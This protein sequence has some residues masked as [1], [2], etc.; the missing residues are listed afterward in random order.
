MALAQL[1]DPRL[2]RAKEEKFAQ[3][4]SASLAPNTI[5]N[6]MAS[7]KKFTSKGYELPASSQDIIKYVVDRAGTDS[8]TDINHV[9]KALRFV[10][11]LNNYID[12]TDNP[13]LKQIMQGIAR[14]FGKAPKRAK[15]FTKEDIEKIRMCLL[16]E[17]EIHS[18][19]NLAL[20]LVGF[21]G[22][23]RASELIK[24]EYRHLTFTDEGLKIFLP[25][26]KTDQT[27]EGHIVYLP[28]LKGV[29]CPVVA[30]E[31]WL[32]VS[33]IK[34]YYVFPAIIGTVNIEIDYKRH[35]QMMSFSN[36][37]K[38]IAKRAGLI[39]P[40]SYSTHSLRRGFAT[41]A[42][43]KGVSL[44]SIQKHGRWESVRNVINYVD[45]GVGFTDNA[46]LAFDD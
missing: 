8:Y 31:N 36:L 5:R 7:L 14:K 16:G 11:K 28:R 18:A 6:Y 41:E 22:A 21:F 19:R 33:K 4:M 30:L 42:A 40:E 34:D 2:I 32:R 15:P 39:E 10:H 12:P 13:R 9:L 27:N 17:E 37:I 20:F 38:R 45:V 46:T 43:K 26:S 23:L 1:T 35:I 25:R 24:I 44:V 29:L 3:L